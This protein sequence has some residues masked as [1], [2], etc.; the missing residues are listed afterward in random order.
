MEGHLPFI[1]ERGGQQFGRGNGGQIL[2]KSTSDR[3]V[4]EGYGG[5]QGAPRSK[6]TPLGRPLLGADALEDGGY[7]EALYERGGRYS[8]SLQD[9]Q[10][11]M[12]GQKGMP[13]TKEEREEEE[14][15]RHY[16]P[17]PKVKHNFSSVYGVG[18]GG[19]G[20]SGKGRRRSGPDGGRDGASSKMMSEYDRELF[21]QTTL[22]K[23]PWMTKDS[24]SKR[25]G[26]EATQG[27]G[28]GAGVQGS[29]KGKVPTKR[30]GGSG[31]AQSGRIA[32]GP[33]DVEEDAVLMDKARQEQEEEWLAFKR[34][35]SHNDENVYEQFR[36]DD[37]DG[38]VYYRLMQNRHAHESMVSGIRGR[39]GGGVGSGSGS[40]DTS[41]LPRSR[42]DLLRVETSNSHASHAS[43]P[44]S[45]G[46]ASSHSRGRGASSLPTSGCTTPQVPG[47][48]ARFAGG[49]R[50]SPMD[51]RDVV[52]GS[53]GGSG[54]GSPVEKRERGGGG[55]PSPDKKLGRTAVPLLE[56]EE[57]EDEWDEERELEHV[58]EALVT[59]WI[60]HEFET[61][62]TTNRS[63]PPFPS[64]PPPLALA[65][66][67]CAERTILEFETLLTTSLLLSRSCSPARSLARSPATVPLFSPGALLPPAFP[68]SPRHSRHFHLST[69]PS[70]PPPCHP[71]SLATGFT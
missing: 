50:E 51:D 14:H 13:K 27:R 16:V 43:T 41:L 5:R 24:K 40:A 53:G 29:K 57:E 32:G 22:E 70:P 31:G 63:P 18:G 9:H 2:P 39:P 55:L 34:M 19:V 23:L 26:G 68:S 48:K 45:R 4:S 56:R 71:P 25:S 47:G 54:R 1:S 38:H 36:A 17:P 10:A 69:L 44:N 28:G 58:L 12:R 8:S 20:K 67:L 59:E 30:A 62:L 35:Q 65:L 49:G 6:S 60:I 42:F 46:G 15:D 64:P 61:I 3:W 52:G 7:D 11:R 37:D 66:S 21:S 33:Y